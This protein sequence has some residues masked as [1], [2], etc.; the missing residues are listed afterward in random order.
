MNSSGPTGESDLESVAISSDDGSD[1]GWSVISDGNDFVV[2]DPAETTQHY[3]DARPKRRSNLARR[4][5]KL[6]ARLSTLRVR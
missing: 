5:S 1:D 2:V 6:Q 3:S 4:V